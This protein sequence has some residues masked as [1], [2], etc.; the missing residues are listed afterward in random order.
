MLTLFLLARPTAHAIKWRPLAAGAVLGL[1]VLLVPEVLVER[2]TDAQLT[3][4]TRIAA[5]GGALGAAFLLDDPSG[6]S[7]RTVPTAR[8]ARYTVRV[9]LAGPAV[10]LWWAGTLVVARRGAHLPAAALTLEAATLLAVALAVSAVA[11][12]RSTDGNTSVVAAP[13]VLLFTAVAF[14]LPQPVELIVRPADPGW[15]ASHHRWAIVLVA[16]LVAF[17][18]GGHERA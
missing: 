17:L 5:L 18:W 15:T 1:A 16:A 12:R 9:V 2:L 11:Q 7:T 6:R 8:L 14:A 10:A 4:L 13:A 3:S